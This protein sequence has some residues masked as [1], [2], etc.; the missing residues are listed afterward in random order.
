MNTAPCLPHQHVTA[1]LGTRPSTTPF[2]TELPGA[3]S[4]EAGAP[5]GIRQYPGY[6]SA[7]VVG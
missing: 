3:A 4:R 5:T 6:A 2:I 1:P 7:N